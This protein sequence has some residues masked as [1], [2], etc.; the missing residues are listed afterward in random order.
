[1][2]LGAH[3]CTQVTRTHKQ[4]ED[5]KKTHRLT[6]PSKSLQSSWTWQ[7]MSLHRARGRPRQGDCVRG[8][9]DLHNGFPAS[10]HYSLRCCLKSNKQTNK[11]KSKTKS[12]QRS[13][14][15]WF[16]FSIWEGQPTIKRN[17]LWNKLESE[18]QMQRKAV[19]INLHTEDNEEK[20][21]SRKNQEKQEAILLGCQQKWDSQST[22]RREAH[23]STAAASG[24][25]QCLRG[26]IPNDIRANVH[27][28]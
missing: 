17:W 3:Q 25:C 11:Q 19:C 12:L 20:A 5:S 16:Y 13:F 15:S 6:L 22:V 27:A 18:V 21:I 1:M 9:F 23:L 7:C 8:Q 26:T 28:S 10:L 14:P 4:K 2:Q 24:T